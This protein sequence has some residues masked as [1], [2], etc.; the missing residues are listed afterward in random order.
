MS[1]RNPSTS[2]LEIEVKFL[3]DDVTA[4]RER[5]VAA[6]GRLHSERVFERNVRF[7]T[8]DNALQGR[9]A[10]LRLRKD[11]SIT[12]TFKGLPHPLPT[13]EARVREEL[14]VRVDDYDATVAIMNRL[15]FLARQAYEKY[16]ET[17][18]LGDVEVVIDEL[19]FGEFVELEGNEAAIKA[20]S[21]ML[22]L[23]WDRRITAN[24]LALMAL[25]KEHHN[26]QFDDLTFAN[27]EG[28]DV[29]V[30]DVIA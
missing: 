16:R 19:P 30:A 10:L 14:E 28:L 18:V 24:Y 8:A 1:D 3:L 4:L 13:S 15:G 12:L 6:G 17:F 2:N 27:F 29:S 26:L 11:R 5:L 25:L 20:A 9:D 23:D 22:G 21:T 7:D